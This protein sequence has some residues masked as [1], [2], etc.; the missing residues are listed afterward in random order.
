MMSSTHLIRMLITPDGTQISVEY[1][2]SPR[3]GDGLSNHDIGGVPEIGNSG[4]PAAVAARKTCVFPFRYYLSGLAVQQKVAVPG[5]PGVTVDY[6]HLL[7]LEEL[8]QESFVPEGLK[9]LVRVKPFLDSVEAE[10]IRTDRRRS[11]S[12]D[13]FHGPTTII[14]GDQY[15]AHEMSFNQTWKQVENSIDLKTLAEELTKVQ[16]HM[17]EDASQASDPA[18]IGNIMRAQKAAQDGDGPGMLR[19]IKAAGRRA[20]DVGI[21][22]G[23]PIAVAAGKAALSI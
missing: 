9:E 14:Y 3:M 2:D 8:R 21:T 16:Q 15:S 10:E 12:R 18:A 1:C 13:T 23:T 11:G 5:H 22:I 7:N 20:L 19:F 6:G 4:V 17:L